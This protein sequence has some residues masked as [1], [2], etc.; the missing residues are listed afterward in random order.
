MSDQ[1]QVEE[2]QT[3][4]EATT[5]EQKHQDSVTDDEVVGEID[6]TPFS[7]IWSQ[8]TD[9]TTSETEEKEEEVASLD[10]ESQFELQLMVATVTLGA[11]WVV[12][13]VLAAMVSTLLGGVGAGIVML[14]S[15]VLVYTFT[16]YAIFKH[17]DEK[18]FKF[19]R[20][21]EYADTEYTHVDLEDENGKCVMCGAEE[22]EAIKHET[23]KNFF[24]GNE[25]LNKGEQIVTYDCLNCA[26][27]SNVTGLEQTD[28][29]EETLTSDDMATE[30]SEETKESQ[31]QSDSGSCHISRYDSVPSDKND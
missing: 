1:V 11:Y 2:E 7:Q 30:S 25:P 15:V 10:E 17:H 21:G 16:G 6:D 24:I 19:P 5:S 20:I 27:L 3:D 29:A 8:K 9:E 12:S 31:S 18:F 14:L 28:A 26:N 23:K 22:G 4:T 13:P